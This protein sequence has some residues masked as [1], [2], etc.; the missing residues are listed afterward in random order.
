VIELPRGVCQQT[1]SG[2]GLGLVAVMIIEVR[3]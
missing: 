3:S 2:L 1:G